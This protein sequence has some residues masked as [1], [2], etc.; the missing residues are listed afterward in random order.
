MIM[1]E[2]GQV[3]YDRFSSGGSYYYQVLPRSCC[4]YSARESATTAIRNVNISPSDVSLAL[5]RRTSHIFYCTLSIPA[6][7]FQPPYP[8]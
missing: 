8:V 3:A 2:C 1:V 4:G 7:L 6:F 5:L